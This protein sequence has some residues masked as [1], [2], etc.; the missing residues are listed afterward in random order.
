MN[1]I[2]IG[3]IENDKTYNFKTQYDEENEIFSNL[4]SCK[5]YE[6][7]D[8][9]KLHSN[10]F[11]NF[12]IYSHNIRSINGHW[13]DI[14]DIVNT[15]LPFKFSVLAFQ[16]IWSV[17]KTFTIPGYSKFEFISRDQ[18]GPLNPN[19]G[20]GVGFFI[21]EKYADYEILADES[22]F[23]PHVYESIWLKIKMKNGPDKIIGNVYRPNTA[24]LANLQ[25]SID[26]HNQIIEQLLSNNNHKK[27]DILI[28][29]D[30]NVNM[31]NF[32]THGLTN[33]YINSLVSKSFLPVIN[34]PTRINHQSATLI[35]HIWTNKVCN[36][37]NSGILIN[38]L[39][40]HFPVFYFEEGKKRKV[41]LPENIT[42]HIN[43]KTIP[44]FCKLLK[45]TSWSNV[46]N[47]QN[48]KIAFANFFELFDSAR[49][50]SFPKVKV[51]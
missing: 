9:S 48:P 18:N 49:D 30:F 42:R 40:D 5:Y 8:I 31:L 25:R 46:L 24:P 50:L 11:E 20:G 19:C 4:H 22:V 39:S 45:S 7:E 1:D 3:Q 38:S 14:L 2:G 51:G 36:F 16:E 6:M 23:I 28:L 17:Q 10:K 29:G 26:I 34:L 27:C 15:A 33:D 12:S 21:D 37:Y 47:Q 41:D 13:D 43:S 35:D 44:G 32:E